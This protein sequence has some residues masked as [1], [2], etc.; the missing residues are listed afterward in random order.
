MH[1][2]RVGHLT[3]ERVD[4]LSRVHVSSM[5]CFHGNIFRLCI[6]I[7]NSTFTKRHF[8]DWRKVIMLSL[9]HVAS[10]VF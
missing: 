1:T 8:Y 6:L 10:V 7:F 5:I 3:G 4:M 2:S 9:E